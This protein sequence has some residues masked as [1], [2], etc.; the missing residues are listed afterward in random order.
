MMHSEKRPYSC[1]ICKKTFSTPSVL[2]IHKLVIIKYILVMLIPKNHLQQVHER[3]RDF[4]CEMCGRKFARIDKLKDHMK[5]HQN[6]RNHTCQFCNR[7]Y[8]EKRDLR[9]HLTKCG[10]NKVKAKVVTRKQNF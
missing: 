9:N 4:T 5:R 2:K 7:K 10:P 6:I 3:S 1:E 8:H